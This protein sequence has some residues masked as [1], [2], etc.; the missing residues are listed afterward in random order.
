MDPGNE[1]AL[2]DRYL[3]IHFRLRKSEN[4]ISWWLSKNDSKTDVKKIQVLLLCSRKLKYQRFGL[5]S[6][7]QCSLHGSVNWRGDSWHVPASHSRFFFKYTEKTLPWVPEVFLARFPVS[8]TSLFWPARKTSGAERD[9]FEG[10]E[11]MTRKFKSKK[12]RIWT[13]KLIGS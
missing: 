7:S 1:V 9:F 12:S 10:A 3:G 4:N 8:V 11:P 6:M 2:I 13:R 5:N